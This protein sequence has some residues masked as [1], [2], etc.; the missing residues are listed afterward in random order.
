MF[1]CQVLNLH[2]TYIASNDAYAYM[3]GTLPTYLEQQN[4]CSIYFCLTNSHSY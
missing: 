3:H 4:W 2:Y 1:T